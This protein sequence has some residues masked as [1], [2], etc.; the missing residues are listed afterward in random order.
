MVSRVES[1]MF[2]SHCHL[3]SDALAADHAGVL[4][5]AREAGVT[6]LLNIGDSLE[7]S[8]AALRQA[9]AA[10]SPETPEEVAMWASAGVHPQNANEYSSETTGA[11]LRELAAQP[12]VCAIGEIGL[13]FVYDETHPQYPCATRAVQE[14]VLRAQLDLAAELEMPVVLHNR[15]A[16]DALP[17]IVAEYSGRINGVFHCFGSAPEVARRVLD[18][19]FYLGFTGLVTFKN[20]AQVRDAALLCP[21]D[22][23]LIE[24]DSP[25]LAPVPH[26][27]KIN[28]P[29]YLPRIA[30]TIAGLRGMDAAQ[31]AQ[32]TARNARRL[33]RLERGEKV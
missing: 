10:A 28:E 13:D 9:Q 12:L 26:R 16:D 15:E 14:R 1:S 11:Q 31:L 32:R 22:R 18:L 27:G 5:R 8:R 7:S 2:D 6:Q 23:L 20:A 30:E 19:G 25:Y 33:F 21:L 3:T 29:S 4:R 24:T 17:A